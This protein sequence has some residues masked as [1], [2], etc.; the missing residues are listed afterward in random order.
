MGKAVK[1]PS[2]QGTPS[3]PR[4]VPNRKTRDA[5]QAAERGEVEDCRDTDDLL[6]KFKS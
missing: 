1:N 4:E 2:R 5:M 3:D 6:K